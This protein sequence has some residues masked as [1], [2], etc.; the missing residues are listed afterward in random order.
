MTNKIYRDLNKIMQ[1]SHNVQFSII[2]SFYKKIKPRSA[3]SEKHLQDYF[4]KNLNTFLPNAKQLYLLTCND[5][6][7]DGLVLLGNDKVPVEVKLTVF[8]EKARWQLLRYMDYTNAQKGIA[9]ARSYTAKSDDRIIFVG[10]E[11]HENEIL[12]NLNCCCKC[13]VHKKN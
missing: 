7:P 2:K 8:N 12:K 3:I 6:K 5:Y 11:T 13:D 9:V 4:F 1:L 10:I